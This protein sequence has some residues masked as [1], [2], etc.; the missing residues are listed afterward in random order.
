MKEDR[1]A[2]RYTVAGGAIGLIAAVA[3]APVTL[4]I[5]VAGLGITAALF[6]FTGIAHAAS[7]LAAG[8]MD[9]VAGSYKSQQSQ[10]EE[11]D[12]SLIV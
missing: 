12:F 1:S 5:A 10:Q 7:A 9:L 11:Y 8:I 2:G 6:F 4:P 3:L